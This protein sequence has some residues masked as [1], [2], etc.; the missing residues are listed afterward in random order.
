M[1]ISLLYVI[2]LTGIISLSGCTLAHRPTAEERHPRVDVG[3]LPGKGDAFLYDVR[4]ERDGRKN[5]AR[6]DVYRQGDSLGIFARGYLGKGVLK[7]LVIPD[8]ITIYFPTENE[9]YQGS[10]A[11]LLK[12]NCPDSAIFEKYLIELFARI[13]SEI[14]PSFSDFYLTILKETNR[15]RDYRLE[16]KDCQESIELKYELREGRF[17][18]EKLNYRTPDDSFRFQATRRQHRLNIVLPVDKF[19]VPIPESATRIL[20][21]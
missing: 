13:P 12:S 2:T 16:S 1:K 17:V 19:S 14:E 20:A 15:D 9:F 5:S 6:L 18:L 10:I 11:N 21:Q 4:V 8:S 7:G 3:V